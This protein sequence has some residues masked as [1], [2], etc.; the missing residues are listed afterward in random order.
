MI[1]LLALEY[2]KTEFELATATILIVS[3]TLIESSI[4]EHIISDR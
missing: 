3:I 2:I 1:V 4:L